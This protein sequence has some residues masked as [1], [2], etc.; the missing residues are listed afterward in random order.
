M[1]KRGSR[2]SKKGKQTKDPWWA[3][4]QQRQDSVTGLDQHDTCPLA[5]PPAKPHWARW[6]VE[7]SQAGQ[8]L[9][10]AFARNEQD[11]LTKGRQAGSFGHRWRH[12]RLAA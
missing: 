11:A 1:A 8:W 9:H 10:E 2:K 3:D 6:V 12:R 4:L 7:L 5:A